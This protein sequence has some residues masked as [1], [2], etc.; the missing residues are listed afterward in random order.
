MHVIPRDVEAALVALAR[1]QHGVAHGRQLRAA[2]LGPHA[3]AGRVERGWLRRLHTGVY[4]V[5]ALESELTAPDRRARR[6]T[7]ATRS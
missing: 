2:G 7:A 4:V 5:G 6:R 1:R 3:I